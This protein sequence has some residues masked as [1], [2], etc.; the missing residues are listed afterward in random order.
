MPVLRAKWEAEELCA[1][2]DRKDIVDACVTPDSDAFLHGARHV[3]K[4]LQA[5]FRE[6]LVECYRAEDIKSSLGLGRKHLLALALLVGCDYDMQG[7]P[8]VGCRSAI[9]L[10]RSFSE[11]AILDELRAWAA[12]RLPSAAEIYQ[13]DTSD[14]EREL[15]QHKESDMLHTGSKSF[16]LPAHVSVGASGND[17]VMKCPHCSCCGHPG[18]KRLHLKSGCQ[19]CG[20]SATKDNVHGCIE[21]QQ[22]FI[23]NCN[24][25]AKLQR[26][27]KRN[28]GRSW[29]IKIF[30]KV[31]STTGFPNEKIIEAFSNCDASSLA[32]DVELRTML[33]WKAPDME[34]LEKFLADKL[35]WDAVYVR[36]KTLPILSFICLSNMRN[37]TCPGFCKYESLLHGEYFPHSIERIKILH[38]RKLYMLRWEHLSGS[39]S[40]KDWLGLKCSQKSEVSMDTCSDK[41]VEKDIGESLGYENQV[42]VGASSFTTLEEMDLVNAACPELVKMLEKQVS[43]KKAKKNN[44]KRKREQVLDRGK[45]QNITSFFRATVCKS[46]LD[47]DIYMTTSGD[48]ELESCDTPVAKEFS[49]W[50][51]E[52]ASVA[53][54]EQVSL[55]SPGTLLSRSEALSDGIELVEVEEPSPICSPYKDWSKNEC[56][57]QT[58]TMWQ[59]LQS[60]ED[61]L[62]LN[63]SDLFKSNVVS[64]SSSHCAL[65]PFGRARTRKNLL[66]A[67]QQADL[68]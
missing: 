30:N 17:S 5:D 2:L 42:I 64:E 27:K 49:K 56:L 58:S 52:L 44:V 67:F 37:S 12:G 59:E 54:E 60:N 10:I 51:T 46:S 34:G 28:K 19:T 22:G 50:S 15:I 65:S 61:V 47:K 39:S 62:V 32:D 3:I 36:Q 21:K 57:S 53:V 45:Q 7:V 35:S 23:C 41:D 31:V 26:R 43:M 38:A 13:H 55:Q 68:P 48:T 16:E 4:Y 1:E 25:C 24:T 9:R 6:P 33:T 63:S 40:S 11:E 29:W 14:S 66:K 18:N 8:G 20:T